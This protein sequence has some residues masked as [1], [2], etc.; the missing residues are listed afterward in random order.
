MGPSQCRCYTSDKQ[1]EQQIN[2]SKPRLSKNNSNVK[3]KFSPNEKD[4]ELYKSNI[5]KIIKLQSRGRGYLIRKKYK[6]KIPSNLVR[7]EYKTPILSVPYKEIENVPNYLTKEVQ[8]TITKLGLF[9]YDPP[10]INVDFGKLIKRG[11]CEIDNQAIYDG[12]WTE[13]NQRQGKG[14][15]IW[16]DG[17]IYEGYWLNDTAYYRGRLIHSDGDVY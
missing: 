15:Q 10:P 9:N 16:T 5:N 3:E 2:S 7:E 12:E 1:I 14:K 8:E 4:I 6:N 17:S 13:N 11:P